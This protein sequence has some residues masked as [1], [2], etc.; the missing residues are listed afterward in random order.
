MNK[1]LVTGGTGYIGSHTVVELINAGYETVIVDNL[2]NS[3]L[4]ILDRIEQIT[5][6]KPKFYQIDL[7]EREKVVELF[8]AE[9]NIDAVIH[10]AAFKAVGESVKEPLKYFRNNNLSLINLLEVMSEVN[11]NNVVFSSSATVYGQPDVLPATESTP[12]QKALSAYGSTKQMGEEMLEKVSAATAIKSIALRYFNPVGAHK[13]ALIGELPVGI[14]NNLMPFVTQTGIGKREQLTIFG[15]DYSTP[16][17][18]CI[19][20][21]IHVVDLAKAHVKACERLLQGKAEESYEVFNLGTGKGTTVL[22]IVNA[23]EKVTGQTLKYKIGE[24]R[25]GDVESLYAETKLANNKLGWKAELGLD[26]MLSS[27]WAWEVK[28]HEGIVNA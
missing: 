10:F 4:F 8:K 26:E 5:G 9:G 13:S 14:P 28:L 23:F 24:R 12:F 1:V 15:A 27:A 25:V 21:Y 7:C 3:E 18:T 11:V 22:E 20:D 2:S 6:V 19:R 16:D 17:G